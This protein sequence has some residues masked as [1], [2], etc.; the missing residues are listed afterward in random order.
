MRVILA[1]ALALAVL[2]ILAS[3]CFADEVPLLDGHTLQG[4]VLDVTAKGLKLEIH[5]KDGGTVVMHMS[6]D[7]LDPHWWYGKRDAALGDDAKLRLDLAVWA[8]EHGLFR[9]GKAQFEKARKLDPKVAKEFRDDVV[10]GLRAG[11]ASD[12]VHSA[13]LQMDA[14][15]LKAANKMLQAVLTRFGD[16][17]AAADARALMPALQHRSD[18]KL[19]ELAHWKKFGDDE[20]AREQVDQRKRVTD[21]IV[22]LIR[23]G[24]NIMGHMPPMAAQAEAVG[25]AQEPNAR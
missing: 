1:L 3:H 8:I 19:K 5:P 11:I 17:H 25:S 21:P 7:H 20:R 24:H 16:T 10:P 14:G 12:L 9:Q 13:H 22:A 15:N 2:P 18:L 6:A 4:K 23:Q